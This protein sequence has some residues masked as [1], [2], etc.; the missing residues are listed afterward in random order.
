MLSTEQLGILRKALEDE[1][2]QLREDVENLRPDQS[3]QDT[4]SGVGNHPAE[5]ALLT[6]TQ[7]QVAGM[8]L[9]QQSVLDDV[10][11][12][13]RRMDDGDYGICERCGMEIGFER[14]QARPE[15]WLCMNCQRIAE[16]SGG[17]GD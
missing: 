7:E 2:A 12:A 15:A 17:R 8:Q 9:H 14:L 1:R 5:A 13:L 10:E 11:E 3:A 16:S 6:E 4:N